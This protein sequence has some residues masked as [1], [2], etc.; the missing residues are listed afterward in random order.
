MILAKLLNLANRC[1]YGNRSRFYDVKKRLLHRYGTRTKGQVQHIVNQC[2]GEYEESC[3][4]LCRRCGGTG[5]YSE[6]WCF[7]ERWE[8]GGFVFHVPMARVWFPPKEPPEIVGRIQH[9]E[10]GWLGLEAA[11]WLYLLSGE[12][13]EF[14][15]ELCD[16]V[17]CGWY[18]YPLLNL[19]RFLSLAICDWRRTNPENYSGI[20]RWHLPWPKKEDLPF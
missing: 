18:A 15:E 4:P 12:L 9:E 17:Y 7:L 11:L 19:Q 16:G 14:F 20:V 3:G 1:R 5:I 10:T 13:E 2:W 6:F 8:W